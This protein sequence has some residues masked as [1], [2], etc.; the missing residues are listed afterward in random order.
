MAVA[1]AW[2]LPLQSSVVAACRHRLNLQAGFRLI[3]L[4]IKKSTTKEITF[5]DYTCHV[6]FRCCGP[7]PAA[8]IGRQYMMLICRFCDA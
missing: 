5:H 4:M 2:C 7:I 8:T 1:N 3:R 6:A